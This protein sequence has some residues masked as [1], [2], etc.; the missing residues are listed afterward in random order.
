MELKEFIKSTISQ[1]GD[2]VSELNQD[3]NGL[4]VNPNFSE[5]RNHIEYRNEAFVMTTIDFHIDLAVDE[6]NLK[7]GQVGVLANVIGIGGK[8]EAHK[9][10]QSSTTIDFSL[11]VLLPQG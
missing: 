8:Y 9:Q 11:D 7:N 1:I 3:D 10:S 4:I 2:A 5:S 6:K